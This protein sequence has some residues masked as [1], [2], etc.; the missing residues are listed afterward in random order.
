MG[1]Q[2]AAEGFP[3]P[4]Q[5]KDQL[6]HFDKD[7]NGKLSKDELDAMP[8]AVRERIDQAVRRRPGGDAPRQN[9]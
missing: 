5:F 7:N 3:I 9:D 2:R 1:G 8:E 4:A 6:G